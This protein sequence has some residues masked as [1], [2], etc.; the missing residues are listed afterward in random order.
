MIYPNNTVIII[1]AYN[2]G[3]P[4]IEYYQGYILET[5][6]GNVKY[7]HKELLLC[8]SNIFRTL[9][10]LSKETDIP[11]IVIDDGSPDDTVE[12]VK[13]FQHVY[14]HHQISLL[15][16]LQ[17]VGKGASFIKATENTSEEIEYFITTDADLVI[18]HKMFEQLKQLSKNCNEKESPMNICEVICKD[19]WYR[20]ESCTDLK[21]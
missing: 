1:P 10:L 19:S 18:P 6:S 2:E 20:H 11:I 13:R 12:E 16:N 15:G 8:K 9:Y 7:P 5:L 21:V 17:R 3:T 4:S 14:P